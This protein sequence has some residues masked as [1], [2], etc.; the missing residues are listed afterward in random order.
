M[1]LDRIPTAENL[2]A[3]IFGILAPHYQNTYGHHLRLSRVRLFETPNCWAD[4]DGN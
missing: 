2:A 3:V 4:C 1:I